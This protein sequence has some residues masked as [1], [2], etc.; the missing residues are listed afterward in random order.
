MKFFILTLLFYKEEKTDLEAESS[1]IGSSSFSK[2]AKSKQSSKGKKTRLNRSQTFAKSRSQTSK[3]KPVQAKPVEL[4]HV[5]TKP[6]ANQRS[7]E[8]QA[9]TKYSS[10][11]AFNFKEDLP[12]AG[13]S[14]PMIKSERVPVREKSNLKE[15]GSINKTPVPA[16]NPNLIVNGLTSNGGI[17][18]LMNPLSSR[19]K[20]LPELR[21]RLS[22]EDL[23]SME[24][25]GNEKA[26]VYSFYL[27]LH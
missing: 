20:Y 8:Q 18:K 16:N 11:S 22:L 17:K 6:I 4:Y 1:L 12:K 24:R 19:K 26:G 25:V 2:L 15:F 7:S 27:Y 3:P 5:E 10:K 14:S 9:Y 23:K 21:T 13:H